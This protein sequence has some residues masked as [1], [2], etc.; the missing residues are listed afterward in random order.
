MRAHL[1]LIVGAIVA[2]A[3]SGCTISF[4]PPEITNTQIEV[5]E[6]ASLAVANTVGSVTISGSERVDVD[7]TMSVQSTSLGIIPVNH[8]PPELVTL[9]VD[10]SDG[11]KLHHD[12]FDA[13]GVSVSYDIDAPADIRVAS[14]TSE[15][16]SVTVRNVAGNSILRTSTGSITAENIRGTVVAE[17]S[18]GRVSVTGANAIA[19]I[20][21]DTGS[22][23]AEIRGLDMDF[24]E[25]PITTSTGSIT[26]FINP[27]LD[28]RIHA[29]TSTGSIHV[30][31][32]LGLTLDGFGND[33]LTATMNA[34]GQMFVIE[35]STGSIYLETLDAE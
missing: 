15:T 23:T 31:P 2:V 21:S 33:S 8:T 3:I 1:K 14:V 11:I 22:I 30:D 19:S 6:V 12:P 17:T 27:A 16:G 10:T 26:V 5:P 25:V 28:L 29:E 13:R 7:V 24:D 4:G 32:G 9:A 20:E 35:T 18:T 34:G